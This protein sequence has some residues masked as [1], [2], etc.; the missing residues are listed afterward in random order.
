[1]KL[2]R[3]GLIGLIVGLLIV[4]GLLGYGLQTALNEQRNDD[5]ATEG[6]VDLN[7]ERNDI[8]GTVSL[9]TGDCALRGS[10]NGQSSPSTCKTDNVPAN[11]YVFDYTGQ[12]LPATIRSADLAALGEP[13]YEAKASINGIYHVRDLPDGLYTLVTM[14]N[15]DHSGIS[16]VV[17]V[18][19]QDVEVNLKINLATN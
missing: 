5:S 11:I 16:A 14:V 2:S 17:T 19:S 13:L 9:T 10:I 15:E 3:S 4:G 6:R 12:E 1:M 7:P 8:Y 18:A